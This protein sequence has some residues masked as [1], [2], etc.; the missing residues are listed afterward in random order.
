MD[1][2]W[3]VPTL[4]S[5]LSETVA[6]NVLTVAS[7]RRGGVV[8]GAKT[9]SVRGGV[10]AAVAARFRRSARFLA[11]DNAGSSMAAMTTM[12]AMTTM[13]SIKVK[14][15]GRIFIRMFP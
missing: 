8:L 10:A 5:G 7:A 11:A 14:A 9:G 6:A 15:G 3:A 12:M 1:S 13:S 2:G 4:N